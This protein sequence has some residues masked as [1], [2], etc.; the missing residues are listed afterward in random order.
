MKQ[1][2]LTI[3]LLM[4]CFLA[5]GQD[6]AFVQ[7]KD[8][9]NVQLKEVQVVQDQQRRLDGTFSGTERLSIDQIT[10]M[11]ALMGEADVL[12]A[13]RQ[14]SGVQSVSEGNSGLYVRGGGAGH[15]LFLLDGMELMNPNHLMGLFSVFNPLTT[16]RV[17]V[18]KGHAPVN[19]QGRL[20][21]TIDVK[22]AVPGPSNQGLTVQLGTIS[23]TLAWLERLVDGRLLINVGARKSYLQA[24]GL[25]FSPF[26]SDKQNSVKPH[27]YQFYDL[28]GTVA[29]LV[30]PTTTL[31]LA[32]Y[33]G[34][35][36]FNVTEG[37]QAYVASSNWGN[38]S[39]QIQLT[40]QTQ[41]GGTW[42]FSASDGKTQAGFDGDLL[43]FSLRSKSD[44]W[45]RTIKTHWERPFDKHT[46]HAGMSVSGQQTTPLDI[47][48]DY[49]TDTIDVRRSFD[50][51]LV[52]LY[53]GDQYVSLDDRWHV[54]AGLRFTANATNATQTKVWFNASPIVS[55]AFKPNRSQT[56]NAALSLN[57]QQ[58]HL[59]GLGAVPLPFD[60]WVP[61]MA[62]VAPETAQQLSFGYAFS[63]DNLRFSVEA[64][65][66][67][68]NHL[69]LFN[70]LTEDIATLPLE[71]L[72]YQGMGF[73]YGIDC[74]FET[75]YGAWEGQLAYS[76]AKSRRSFPTIMQGAW[77]NDKNDRPHDVNLQLTY[78]INK[79]WNIGG[80][81]VFASGSNL[82]LP[83]GR[84]FLMGQVMSDYDQ[85]NGFR[86]PPY[87]R[88]DLTARCRLQP[89]VFNSSELLFSL[90][91]V[92]NRANPYYAYFKV[93][94]GESRYQ[95]DVKS[96]QVSLFPLL[97]SISWRFSL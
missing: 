12:Q 91:N 34:E 19:R 68:M 3:T 14:L 32:W 18:Y 5:F 38:G 8:T 7:E 81:W 25:A 36:D 30:N 59:A 20:A 2:L 47:H 45:Q 74:S 94:Q 82:T 66:K 61:S 78:T 64:Y 75:H 97:P 31:S 80:Q 48:T 69:L 89:G 95:M 22:S 65:G 44:F 24:L 79:Q 42:Q 67:K 58:V 16:S 17:D 29:F 70:L 93:Y 50:N 92:Y 96:Y 71:A 26:I 15:N 85:F 77:F 60:L 11:P 54:Y 55:V 33:T 4:R 1:S 56:F 6:T 62:G 27:P 73:A 39:L 49:E 90:I 35:D 43:T 63:N 9:I 23:S 10:S 53:L 21:S 40:H 28:N 88:L 72:L 87:H 84:C 76:Y 37:S 46:L 83:S 41:Q 13:V 51:T 52:S 57:D 86:L